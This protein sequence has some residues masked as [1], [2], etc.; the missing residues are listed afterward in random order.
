VRALALGLLFQGFVLLSIWLLA[1]SISLDAPFSVL[2]VTTPSV[3]ILAALPI[4]IGGFGVRESSFVV[5]LGRAGVS[6]T[7]ATVLSLLS[8][9]AFAVASAPGAVFVVRGA[10]SARPAQAQDREHERRE[11]DLHADDEDACRHERDLALAEPARA[12]R[13]P[14]RDDDHAADEPDEDQRSAE[15]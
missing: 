7:D 12:L 2:A 8:A 11:E 9:A 14:A 6:G 1:R 15:Q 4:S 3:L 5:L 13:D 10:R